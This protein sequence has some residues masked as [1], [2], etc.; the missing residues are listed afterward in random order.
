MTKS[1]IAIAIVSAAGSALGQATPFRGTH[2]GFTTATGTAGEQLDLRT[3]YG[4]SGAPESEQWAY[5]FE[6][7]APGVRELQTRTARHAV[8][9]NAP[10]A[11]AR[12]NLWHDAPSTYIPA[13][14]GGASPVAGWYAQSSFSALH[15][16]TERQTFNPTGGDFFL[17]TGLIDGGNYSYEI[18]DVSPLGGSPDAS[19]A[20][21]L[22]S[23]PAGNTDPALRQLKTVEAGLDIFG[24]YDHNQAGGGSFAERSINLG[25]GNHFHGYGFFVSEQGLYEVSMRVVDLNGRYTTS[26]V[27][28]FQLNSIPTP[29]SAALMGLAGLAAA[30][31]RR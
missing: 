3:G 23:N 12:F 18:L 9:P 13:E 4:T 24:I 29:A 6:T 30:R 2:V 28:T 1:I 22:M 31:R 7:V 26:D 17:A 5:R 15:D 8:D 20:I 21:G 11:I 25:L 27:F 10:F 19:F 16:V 14:G